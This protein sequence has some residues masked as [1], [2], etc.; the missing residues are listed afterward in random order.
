MQKVNNVLRSFARNSIARARKQFFGSRVQALLVSTAQGSFLVD[1]EDMAVGRALIRIGRYGEDEIA[2]ILPLTNCTSNVLFVGSH[3][4][5]L[6]VP[7]SMKVKHVTAIEANPDTYRLL[8]WNLLLNHCANV[9]PIQIAASDRSGELEFVVSRTNSGGSKRMPVV[10]AH[11]YFYDKP[12]VIR[13]G[14][15]RLDDHLSEQFD[16]IV[17]DIEGSEYFALKGMERILSTARHLIVEFLPHHLRNVSGVTVDEFLAVIEP[18]FTQLTIP[19]KSIT[20]ER[21]KFLSTLE[22]MYNLDESDDAMIFSKEC[23]AECG[24]AA[25]QAALEEKQGEVFH[26]S[27]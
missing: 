12:R 6:V 15:V 19:S 27:K 4:G 1:P 23:G 3:I 5:A 18:H 20:V 8:S 7:V 22:R 26:G 10:K 11:E 13:V 9:K 2:R 25:A 21:P 17:M 16:V 24:L 14:A